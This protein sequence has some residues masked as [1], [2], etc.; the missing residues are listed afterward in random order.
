MLRV[1]QN[2]YIFPLKN[3]II[4]TSRGYDEGWQHKFLWYGFCNCNREETVLLKL[5]VMKKLVITST[6]ALLATAWSM[7]GA[8]EYPAEYL[9]LPGDNL[10]LYATMKLFQESET[11]E[12]F[13]KNLNDE[14]SRINNLDLNGDNYIDYIMVIDYVDGDVHSIVL[15]AALDKDETQDVAVFTVQRLRDGSVQVQLVGDEALYGRN[16]I[17]EPIYA[18]NGET[19]NPGYI[20]NSGNNSN[21]AVVRTTTYEVA[22]W[23][24]VRYIYLPTYVSW[25]S[26]WYWGYYPSYWNPW[27]PFY[28]HTYYGYH[29]NWHNHYYRHYRTW[30]HCRYDGYNNFYYNNVRSYSSRVNHRIK[31]GHYNTTYSRPDLRKEG[32]ALYARTNSERSARTRDNSSVNGRRVND[33]KAAQSRSIENNRSG[34]QRSSATNVARRTASGSSVNQGTEN[35]RKS[36]TVRTSRNS[37]NN[38]AR[39]T[40]D[41]SRR[42]EKNASTRF[43]GSSNAVR[44]TNTPRKS[45]EVINKRAVQNPSVRQNTG[46]TQRSSANVSNR[47]IS[48]TREAP[49]SVSSRSSSGQSQTKSAVS[50]RSSSNQSRTAVGS[51]GSSAPTKSAVSSRSSGNQSRSSVS[52][53]NSGSTNRSSGSNGNRDRT[54]S[55]G[56]SGR[57]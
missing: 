34:V 14:N 55:S 22:A 5:E 48:S 41:I 17:I 9:G 35:S 36:A 21:V 30:N 38:S 53:G 8:Q 29:Y 15:R 13:E 40:T 10:N 43:A 6:L 45:A 51:R 37:E 32:E 7:V 27:R 24:V 12:S 23:P 50:S 20:G 18:D 11:L 52:S 2:F 28:W 26:S 47:N 1:K 4:H 46:N 19:P 39:N 49:R 33:P 42:V 31:S 16:Y 25:H 57:R 56:N 54:S 44:E 3:Y